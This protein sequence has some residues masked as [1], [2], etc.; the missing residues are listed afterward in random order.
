MKEFNI[1]RTLK[2][3]GYQRGPISMVYK[4]SDKNPGASGSF[5]KFSTKQNEQ[6]AIIISRQYFRCWS[7]GLTSN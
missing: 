6:L 1:A 2:F 7:L 3:D 4:P 5:F